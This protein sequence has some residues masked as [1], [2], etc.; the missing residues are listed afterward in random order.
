VR[1]LEACGDSGSECFTHSAVGL[2]PLEAWALIQYVSPWRLLN[3]MWLPAL[4]A[5]R[6][7]PCWLPTTSIRSVASAVLRVLL[8]VPGC[9]PGQV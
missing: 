2:N 8:Q 7:A 6:A 9:W 3:G 5:D 1:L 4:Q